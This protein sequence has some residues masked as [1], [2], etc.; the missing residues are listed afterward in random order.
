MAIDFIIG[1]KIGMTRVFDNQ[2][3]DYPVTILA[4]TCGD[5]AKRV[6]VRI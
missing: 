1:R 6:I 2:G 3:F 4:R 5:G